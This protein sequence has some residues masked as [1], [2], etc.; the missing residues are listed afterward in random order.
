MRLIAISLLI[1]FL[2]GGCASV[3]KQ[4]IQEVFKAKNPLEGEAFQSTLD[5][6]QK[7]W[8][9]IP[10]TTSS[11]KNAALLSE[12]C[13]AS[14]PQ[15]TSA[16]RQCLKATCW[17]AERDEKSQRRRWAER[18]VHLGRA[19]LELAPNEAESH[20]RLALALAFFTRETV[21]KTYLNEMAELAERSVEIDPNYDGAGGQRF[22][23]RL[24]AH[25]PAFP[26]SIG[27][28][29]EAYDWIEEAIQRAPEHPLNWLSKAHILHQ[30][31]RNAE[32][33]RPA[34][35]TLELI[36]SHPNRYPDSPHW[37]LDTRRLLAKIS[38]S[39]QR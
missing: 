24:Y 15:D 35:K 21:S 29:E 27:D 14:R 25:A 8:S 31:E 16:I 9:D 23:A 12:H 4:E 2:T 37:A 7:H 10:R 30:D 6:A 36:R 39:S 32:A 19:L 5:K 20:Y 28:M 17:L 3:E 22:L 1:L 13:V 26:V 18:A 34:N 33:I 11:V 38:P